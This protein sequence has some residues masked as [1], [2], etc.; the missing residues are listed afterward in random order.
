ML[1]MKKI[2]LIDDEP[3]MVKLLEYCLKYNNYKVITATN[4]VEGF[5]RTVYEKPDL[6]VLDVVMSQLDGYG[7]VK[8]LNRRE[9]LK[10][11]PIVV[12]TGRDNLQNIFKDE[13][14]DNYFM[15]PFETKD[16]LNRIE[17]LLGNR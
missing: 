5:A 7:F 9:N 10:T 17:E 2:L 15:K 4:G 12:L 14:I 1:L 3:N 6:I 13:G 16:V 8:E 11:I